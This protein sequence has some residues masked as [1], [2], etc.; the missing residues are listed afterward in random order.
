MYSLWQ[1]VQQKVTVTATREDA[2]AEE[3]ADL[4]WLW[5]K[6]STLGP[7][8]QTYCEVFRSS[9]GLGPVAKL[10]NI[11][12]CLDSNEPVDVGGIGIPFCMSDSEG[13]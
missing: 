1:G 5:E 2:F 12:Q 10:E 7:S 3:G 13:E 4:S 6:I 9:S 11:L 8:Q